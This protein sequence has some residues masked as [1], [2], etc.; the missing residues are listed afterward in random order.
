[1]SAFG[2]LWERPEA[3]TGELLHKW[4]SPPDNPQAA[5]SL[6]VFLSKQWYSVRHCFHYLGTLGW[7]AGE[8]VCGGFG[9]SNAR[10]PWSLA[11]TCGFKPAK[12]WKG[13][14]LFLAPTGQLQEH[15]TAQP[16]LLTGPAHPQGSLFCPQ[17]L[18]QH[19][20]ERLARQGWSTKTGRELLA[21]LGACQSIPYAAGGSPEVEMGP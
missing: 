3:F 4:I 6:L 8:E 5:L 19:L 1:M 12:P 15:P 2:W 16:V 18:F 13:E 20:L 9:C 17:W 7:E 21:S 14:T 11:P 10:L